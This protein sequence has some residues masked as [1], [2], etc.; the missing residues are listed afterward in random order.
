MVDTATSR[1]GARKQSLGSNV[2]TWGDTNLNDVLDLFDRGS[3]GY[4]AITMTGDTTVTWTNY[5]TTNQGQVQTLKLNGSLSSAANFII[6]SREW[7]FTVINNTGVTVTVKTSAGTGVAIP[8]S[9]QADV[10]CDATNVV[11]GATFFNGVVRGST[12]VASNDLTTLTQ[13]SALIAAS[14]TSTTPGTVKITASDTTAKYLQST[15]TVQISSATTTQLSGL[16]SLQIALLNAG[17][18]EQ[19]AFQVAPG[20]VGGFL[21]GGTK[22]SAFTP[23]VG[24]AYDVDMSTPFT[25]QLGSMTTPQVGQEFKLNTFGNGNIYLNSTVNG[26]SGFTY[27]VNDVKVFR[28]SGSTWGWN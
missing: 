19:L 14:T 3:K 28:Y 12:A 10:Y 6:P 17:G 7:A 21:D 2:N 22:S 9:Y 18:N 15:V 11:A 20:Y 4:E 27:D 5:A 25:V 24:S 23:V 26:V 1:Y 8:T 13:V 16:S